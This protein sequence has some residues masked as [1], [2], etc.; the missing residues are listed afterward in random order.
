MEAAGSS[1]A[2][3][4]PVDSQLDHSAY[5]QEFCT[6]DTRH[7]VT[8]CAGVSDAVSVAE[9]KAQCAR[10]LE[11]VESDSLTRTVSNMPAGPMRDFGL[12]EMMGISSAELEAVK[13][14]CE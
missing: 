9:F 3:M 7:L 4:D 14:E 2:A 11:I 8:D 5:A 13:Q 10:H 6:W 1:G 12:T